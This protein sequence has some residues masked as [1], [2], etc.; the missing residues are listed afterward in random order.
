MW[1]V[2]IPPWAIH[3]LFSKIPMTTDLADQSKKAQSPIVIPVAVFCLFNAAQYAIYVDLQILGPDR[4]LFHHS[5]LGPDFYQF[6]AFHIVY[7]LMLTSY[8]RIIL[9]RPGSIPDSHVWI[10]NE[11]DNAQAKFSL[12]ANELEL[13]QKIMEPDFFPYTEPLRQRIRRLPFVELKNS[14]TSSN[15]IRVCRKCDPARYKPDRAHHCTKSN[16]CVLAMDHYCTFAGSTI[17]FVNRKFFILFIMYSFASGCLFVS[18]LSWRLSS[19]V[20]HL[21][22]GQFSIGRDF[23]IILSCAS[24]ICICACLALFF[25][26]HIY[27]MVNAMT[28]IEF[29]EKRGSSDPDVRRKSLISRIKFNRGYLGNFTE[30]FGTAWYFWLL[31]IQSDFGGS[32]GLYCDIMYRQGTRTDSSKIDYPTANLSL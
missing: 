21:F 11:R 23:P 10:Y 28:T 31:P 18:S 24:V 25:S 32:D 5:Q 17:G 26:F 1:Y 3:H 8:A 6:V 4:H 13:M 19:A 30:V 14:A 20:E 29:R 2:P 7:F 12:S 27:I 9:T 15:S 16:S 22:D